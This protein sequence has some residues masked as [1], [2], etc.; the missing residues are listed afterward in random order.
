MDKPMTIAEAEVLVEDFDRL[1]D[2]ISQTAPS[3]ARLVEQMAELRARRSEAR[4]VLARASH[5]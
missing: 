5:E 1:A 2:F 4:R 3:M